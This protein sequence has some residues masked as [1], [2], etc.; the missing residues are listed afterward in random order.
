MV[1]YSASVCVCVC[2][3]TCDGELHVHIRREELHVAT[4]KG[5]SLVEC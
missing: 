2:V 1:W 3:C 5:C 4:I